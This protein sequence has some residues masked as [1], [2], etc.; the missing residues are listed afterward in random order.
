MHRIALA[1]ALAAPATLS[2]QHYLKPQVDSLHAA[3]VAA[4]MTAPSATA[5]FYTDDAAVVG[6]GTRVTG[7]AG[8]DN[9][10]KEIPTGST[11]AL[12]V[13]DVGGSA[14][15]PWVHGRSTLTT[16]GRVSLTE[17]IGLLQRGKDGQLRFRV[18]AYAG[19]AVPAS[20]EADEATIRRLDST[21]AGIYATHDT[22][23]AMQLYSRSLVFTSANGRQKTLAEEL[24]DVRPAQGLTMEYFRTTPTL[25]RTYDRVALVEG[26]ASWRF[27]MNGAAREVRRTYTAIYGRG[28]PLG[29]RILAISMGNAP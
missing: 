5:R 14:D 29:W 4:F 25:V 8:I 18:D 27:T 13:L 28:G 15:A 23:T 9:Y 12:E 24:A 11:W 3:M 21:W 2:A 20:K 6:G 10:W 17:Y 7:R 26:S 1:L 22:A 19:G 16:N